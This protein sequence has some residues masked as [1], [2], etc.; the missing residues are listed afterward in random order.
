MNNT[1]TDISSDNIVGVTLDVPGQS[2]VTDLDQPA[3]GHQDVPSCQVSMDTLL[4]WQ[5]IVT[6]MLKK[7]KHLIYSVSYVLGGEEL[8]ALGHLERKAEQIIKGQGLQKLRL[9]IL[10]LLNDF[11]MC[12]WTQFG[13]FVILIWWFGCY[14][15]HLQSYY[16]CYQRRERRGR[17]SPAL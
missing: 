9:I 11:W 13:P 5:L 17:C 4:R 7:L 2:E 10:K 8:H 6:F 3:F 12:T 16:P 1:C 15:F 14:C